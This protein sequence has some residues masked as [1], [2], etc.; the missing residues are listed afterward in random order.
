MPVATQDE[1]EQV[2]SSP[3]T[4]QGDSTRTYNLPPPTT[5]QRQ[6]A[7]EMQ[8]VQ[9]AYV[10]MG[11]DPLDPN[12]RP[13]PQL[14]P[15]KHLE[16]E[17]GCAGCGKSETDLGH[18]LTKICSRCTLYD[19]YLRYCNEECQKK[20]WKAHRPFCGSVLSGIS[21]TPQ[22][23]MPA[24]MDGRHWEIAS[25]KVHHTWDVFVKIGD[26]LQTMK[27]VIDASRLL[28]ETTQRHHRGNPTVDLNHARPQHPVAALEGYKFENL[29]MFLDKTLEDD[30]QDNF[31]PTW[32]TR[33]KRDE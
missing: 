28:D 14:R 10:R 19:P 12:K 9:T 5:L 26:H 25:Q 8:V 6:L 32:W 1:A 16:Y 2:P 21:G 20:G 11:L 33:E 18:R 27:M 13:P 17:N 23:L 29:Q 24:R 22:Q 3:G 30:A 4:R 15:Y 31:M 7:A